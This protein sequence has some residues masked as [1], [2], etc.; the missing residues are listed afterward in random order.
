MI[1]R[2]FSTVGI[3]LKLQNY[4]NYTLSHKL[5]KLLPPFNQKSGSPELVLVVIEQLFVSCFELH[6][7]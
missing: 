2:R 3:D 7:I 5:I 4:R 6:C 1:R